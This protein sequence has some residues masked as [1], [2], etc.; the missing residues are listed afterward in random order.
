M[1][2]PPSAVKSEVYTAASS[3]AVADSSR[4][5]VFVDDLGTGEELQEVLHSRLRRKRAR[6][7]AEQ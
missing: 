2:Q 3:A 1:Q 7:A 5:A 4:N 6:R